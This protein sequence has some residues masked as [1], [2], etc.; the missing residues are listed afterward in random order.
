MGSP[1]LLKDDEILLEKFLALESRRDISRLLEIDNRKFSF[2]LY[3]EKRIRPQYSEFKIKKKS[4]GERRILAPI[5]TL[6]IL[7][8]KLNYILQ[9]IYRPNISAHG[10]IVDRSI[11]TNA[12]IHVGKKVV[13]N[14]DLENF[15]PSINFG[16]V[17]GLFL[18][19]P[20]NFNS[21][22]ATTLAQ[23]CCYDGALPQGAP[24]SPTISNMICARLDKELRGLAIRRRCFY[25]RYADD[26]TFSTNATS[27]HSDI[28][29]HTLDENYR[30][31]VWAGD[32]L[33]DI[34]HWN[35]F[36]INTKKIRLAAKDRKKEVTGIVVNKRLNVSRTY[37]R[38][39]RSMLY[40][41]EKF[42]LKGAEEEHFK[43]YDFGNRLMVSSR[44]YKDIVKGKID[45]IGLVRGKDDYIYKN[46][47]NRFNKLIRNGRAEFPI[48]QDGFLKSSIFIIRCGS[49]QGTGFLLRGVGLITCN[50]V[51]DGDPEIRVYKWNA[52]ANEDKY[53]AKIIFS[54]QNKDLAILKVDFP[55]NIYLGSFILGDSCCG[56]GTRV[57]CVG[58][59][60][61][62][63]GDSY[64]KSE[65]SIDSER[66]DKRGNQLY[67]FNKDLYSG[68]SGGPAFDSN[69]KVMGIMFTGSDTPGVRDNV[70]EFGLIP[71]DMI[72]DFIIEKRSRLIK[73]VINVLKTMK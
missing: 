59:P 8:R 46:F 2:L 20:F 52:V 4:G 62:R 38:K 27:F 28:E 1:F 57:T 58:F 30:V 11:L 72:R 55:P 39:I 14:V 26:I 23:L 32:K 73:Q 7:Q 6:K 71:L 60:D 3:A 25:T 41:W 21:E 17:R 66:K 67:C 49:K 18:S 35:G 13:F 9:L 36:K 44:S 63:L 61:Y 70:A 24:T 47:Y 37:I 33:Q 53:E 12:E 45:Y 5:S 69:K 15:F 54:D 16:R 42:D 56:I 50:H 68:Q 29:E 48:N 64:K 22:V 31:V 19:K 40:A 43:K 34:I 10:F 65:G 51:V